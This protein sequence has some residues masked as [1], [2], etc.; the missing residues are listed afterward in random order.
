MTEKELYQKLAKHLDQGIVGA[1]AS[2]ALIGILEILFPAEEAKVAAKLP[3]Q[4]QTLAELEEL[5]PEVGDS[6][7]AILSRMVRRGTVFTSR[8]PGGD[9]KYRL[10]PSVVGWAETPFWEGKDSEDRRK[11]APRTCGP[12]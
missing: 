12:A 6:L 4:N 1:P 8:R 3:M 11:L 5:F 9:R 7:E 2:P 10:L